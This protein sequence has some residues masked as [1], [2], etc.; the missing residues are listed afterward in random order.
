MP[1]SSK[2]LALITGASSGIGYELACCAARDGYDLVVVADEHD[3][4]NA[5]ERLA[6]FGVRVEP[7]IEDLSTMA[8]VDR[9]LAFI[10]NLTDPVELLMANAGRGLGGAFLDQDLEIVQHIID[11]N[12]GGTLA[13]VHGVGNRML[14]RGRGR[15]LLTGSIAGFVPGAFQAVYNSTK[16]FINSF[17]LALRE[18]LNGTGITVTC[19]MPGATETKFFERAAML[20]TPIARQHKDDPAEVARVGYAAMLAGE[21]DVVSGMKN[22][23]IATAANF[24]PATVLA[25]QQRKMSEPD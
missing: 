21:A 22:K 16:S 7:L 25:A 10:A 9:V 20:D 17:S 18:E 6:G 4:L 2:G 19:L 12:V 8:G 24:T 14:R 15:I 13:L 1:A 23:L 3:I 11:T 5:A